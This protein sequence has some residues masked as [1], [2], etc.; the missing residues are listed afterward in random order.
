MV[1]NTASHATEDDVY[2]HFSDSCSTLVQLQ[3]AV[4]CLCARAMLEHLSIMQKSH[5]SLQNIAVPLF[6]TSKN[7]VELYNICEIM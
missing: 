4:A 7:Y 6:I 2:S 3:L 5:R 1:E